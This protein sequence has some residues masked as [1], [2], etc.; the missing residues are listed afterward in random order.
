MALPTGPARSWSQTTD[1]PSRQFESGRNDDELY[2][3]DDV[4]ADI[5]QSASPAP[6]GSF[7]P[8]PWV[9]VERFALPS[10]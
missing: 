7:S 8:V 4:A 10:G 5:H 3:E 1:F 2:E 9:V 6:D